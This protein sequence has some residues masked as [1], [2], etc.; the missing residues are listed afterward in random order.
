MFNKLVIILD[1]VGQV[2][3]KMK[4]AAESRGLTLH[5]IPLYR[6]VSGGFNILN[7]QL[8]ARA[9]GRRRMISEEASHRPAQ[10]VPQPPFLF[11]TTR[12]SQMLREVCEE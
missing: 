3:I 4:L 5:K 8:G 9:R 7:E 2:L 6:V 10:P 12:L 11:T 1:R